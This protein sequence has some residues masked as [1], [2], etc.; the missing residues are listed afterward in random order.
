MDST[1]SRRFNLPSPAFQPQCQASHARRKRPSASSGQSAWWGR[2]ALPVAR[3]DHL[4]LGD[5]QLP[6]LL[7]DDG[8]VVAA[9]VA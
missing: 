4:L 8:R 3:D 2:S 9:Q 7:H 6:A 1:S 5:V